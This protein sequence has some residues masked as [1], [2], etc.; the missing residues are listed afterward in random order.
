[1]KCDLSF[2]K[3]REIACAVL[4]GLHGFQY[5]WPERSE[6]YDALDAMAEAND[7]RLVML[8]GHA[9]VG[10]SSILEAF[11]SKY[12]DQVIVVRPRIYSERLNMIGQVLHAVFPFSEF[13][14]HNHVPDSLI[15]FRKTARKIIVVDDLDI[16]SNQNKMHEV[17]FDQLSQLAG[18]PGDFTIIM[19]TRNKKLLRDYFA[20]KNRATTL[21]PVSGLISASST[22]HVIQGF[23]EWCN[24][25]YGTDVHQP[26]MAQYGK[27]EADMPIDRIV[28]ECESLYCAELLK[29]SPRFNGEEIN[30]G[31]RLRLSISYEEVLQIRHAAEYCAFG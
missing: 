16:I 17:V 10:I 8:S 15:A 9:G 22:K 6:V 27:R 28:F 25:Q 18:F 11:A 29:V 30:L 13:R 26:C 12:H 2:R 3:R 23:F 1:M 5:S 31:D 14:S 24:R 19:S 4:E 20:I 21:I 7:A